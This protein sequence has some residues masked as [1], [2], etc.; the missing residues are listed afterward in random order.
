M[1]RAVGWGTQGTVDL[2]EGRV[3]VVLVLAPAQ[4]TVLDIG[5][6][7]VQGMDIAFGVVVAC[8]GCKG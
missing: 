8:M 4:V 2:V 7:V 1:G 3:V 6:V 5:V